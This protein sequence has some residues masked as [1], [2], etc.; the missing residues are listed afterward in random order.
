MSENNDV[1]YKKCS[2]VCQKLLEVNKDNFRIIKY[3]TGSTGFRSWC[4]ICEIEYT[5]KYNEE[6]KEEKIIYNKQWRENNPGYKKEYREK[7]KDH[8]NEKE[9][10]YEKTPKRVAYNKLRNAEKP[11]KSGRHI[12]EENG[13]KYQICTAKCKRKLEICEENFS[14]TENKQKTKFLFNRQCKECITERNSI[15][16]TEYRKNN[17][18]I[19]RQKDHEYRN[20][21]E[22]RTRQREKEREK[23]KNPIFRLRGNISGHITTALIRNNGSKHGM[24][25]FDYLP[26]SYKKL[27]Q[28]I[29]SQF[30]DWM[31]WDN[32]GMYILAEWDDNDKSTWKWNLD[33]IDPQA[34]FEYASMADPDFFECWALSNLRPYSAKQNAID[35]ATRVRHKKN[36]NKHNKD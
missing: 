3:K 29:E 19:I 33:H 20:R 2:G 17:R 5:K 12:I 7:N 4:R 23:R 15:Y 35:G 31:T 27:R 6:N 32:Y 8:I 24:S 26:Y 10:E 11:K 34:D 16:S 13:V 9:R 21:P 30:E 18:D 1:K 14:Y 36:R 25:I 28:H 22:V